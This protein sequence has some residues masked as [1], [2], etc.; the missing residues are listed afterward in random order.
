MSVAF[1]PARVSLARSAC[2]RPSVAAHAKAGN[3]LPGADSPAYLDGSKAG[4]YG[5]DPLG[6]ATGD[7]L[8]RLAE[9]EVIHGRWA[10]MGVAGC[11]AVELFGFGDWFDAP[12]WA[13]EGANA[14]YFGVPVPFDIK[15]LI[16]LELVLM[17]GVEVLRNEE[18]D[19]G[20]R[21]YPG[22]AFD[23]MGMG[24]G[25]GFETAKL[26]EIKNGRLAMM[27]FLGFVSQHYVTGKGPLA[28]LA[29]HL[30]NPAVNNFATNGVS[31]PKFAFPFLY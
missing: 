10:M 17:A 27:A 3:W 2:A 26:K 6:L 18:K 7:S 30:S 31:L 15:T 13:V 16:L 21:M 14:T 9:A 28:N 20:K 11:L 22:G 25:D 8:P 1:A 4:D 24:K 5:F 12:L 29:D 23:P 19:A